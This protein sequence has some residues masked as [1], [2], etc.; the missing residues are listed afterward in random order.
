MVVFNEEPTKKH[1]H[2]LLFHDLNHGYNR[3]IY[4]SQG[5]MKFFRWGV[6]T[7]LKVQIIFIE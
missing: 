7:F 1:L 2:P 6:Q 4:H 5:L 3:W